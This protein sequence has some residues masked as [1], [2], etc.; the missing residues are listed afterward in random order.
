M[1]IVYVERRGRFMSSYP[2]RAAEKMQL[3]W[4]SDIEIANGR[5]R[6]NFDG[7]SEIEIESPGSMN[8]LSRAL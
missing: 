3:R 5:K 2:V 6:S 7:N 8:V 4:I 1:C